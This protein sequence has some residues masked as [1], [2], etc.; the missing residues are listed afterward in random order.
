MLV[1][2][3]GRLGLV[4]G[5]VYRRAEILRRLPGIV[6]SSSM[7]YPDI[8]KTEARPVPA[9]GEVQTQAVLGDERVEV[10]ADRVHDGAEVDGR[11]PVGEAGRSVVAFVISSIT[12]AV[13]FSGGRACRHPDVVAATARS[14]G[15][16]HERSTVERQ[17]WLELSGRR[18]DGSPHVL[19]YGPGLL[20]VSTH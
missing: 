16:E 19:G 6:W 9:T 10:W 13:R 4:G 2:R 3:E 5:G 15:R 12:V 14:I 18:V 7:R 17:T 8:S 11:R 20:R 1:R